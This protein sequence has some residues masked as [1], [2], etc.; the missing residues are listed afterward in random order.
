MILSFRHKGLEKFFTTGSL[1]G[2]QAS[3]AN[4]LRLQ[5]AALNSAITIKD[6]DAPS[7]GLHE[8]KGE[9]KGTWSISING[10]WRL[11]FKSVEGSAEIV[12]YEDYRE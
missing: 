9:R 2:I 1:K 8:L 6:M 4:R 10:N 12:D 3:H 7:Y 11:T 5:L